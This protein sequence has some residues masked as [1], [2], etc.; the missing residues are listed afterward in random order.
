M[1]VSVP[2]DSKPISPTADLP[3][4]KEP[5]TVKQFPNAATVAPKVLSTTDPSTWTVAPTDKTSEPSKAEPSATPSTTSTTS[6][7]KT[8]DTSKPEEPADIQYLELPPDEMDK[9]FGKIPKSSSTP[10]PKGGSSSSSG[11]SSSGDSGDT[12][13]S[14]GGGGG[15]GGKPYVPI[16]PKTISAPISGEPSWAAQQRASQGTPFSTDPEIKKPQDITGA[17]GSIAPASD[18]NADIV[19][20]GNKA[21]MMMTPA[22]AANAQSNVFKPDVSGTEKPVDTTAP[23]DKEFLTVHPSKASESIDRI[24]TL[25][26]LK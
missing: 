14:G 9:I 21:T 20:T 8:P 10:A 3:T 26:G 4:F 2:T 16:T 22:D 12:G 23:D 5:T 11:T 17:A 15:G 13:T 18:A 1:T 6:V 25:A 24:R 7:D 19:S